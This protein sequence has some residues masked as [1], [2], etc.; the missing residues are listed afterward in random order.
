M[1]GRV[2][3]D[4]RAFLRVPVAASTRGPRT[5]IEAWVDTAFTGGLTLPRSLG[6]GLGLEA[7]V[8]PTQCS[9]TA[10]RW[11]WSRSFAISTGSAKRIGRR[12][13]RQM[14]PTHSLAPSCWLAE[15]WLST[16]PLA[17]WN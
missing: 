1:T 2:D 5:E 12:P 13:F 15:G 14:R 16:T 4:G 3:A 17:P 7:G 11:C 9:R 6:A 8:S 10:R